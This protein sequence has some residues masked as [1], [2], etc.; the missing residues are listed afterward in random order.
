MCVPAP[1]VAWDKAGRPLRRSAMCH[2]PCETASD[3]RAF[4]LVTTPHRSSQRGI[5]V[6][7]CIGRCKGR[8]AHCVSRA[9][10]HQCGEG[11]WLK[12]ALY[13][14]SRQILS[15]VMEQIAQNRSYARLLRQHAAA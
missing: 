12:A 3:R 4:L 10:K 7:D 15:A 2:L 5:A 9:P 8:G 13:L 11:I 1:T 14:T 6:V